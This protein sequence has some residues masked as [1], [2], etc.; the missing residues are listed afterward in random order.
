MLKCGITGHS[1][2]LGSQLIKKKFNFKFIIF[3]DDI[4]RKKKIYQWIKKN[5]LDLILH[6]AA[7]VPTKVVENNFSYANSVNYIGTKNLVDAIVE[8]NLNLKWFF[9]SSTS[10]VYSLPKKKIK[11]NEKCKKKAISKYGLTK[12]KAERYIK[13]KLSKSKIPYCIGRIF[14]FTHI[15]Q[16]DFYLIPSIVKKIRKS[17][18]NN[19]VFNNMNHYRDFVSVADI[20]EAIK[21]LWI[22]KSKGEFNIASGKATYIK[23][24]VKFLCKK[25]KKKPIFIDNGKS[26]M[27]GD[28]KK[29]NK[30]GWKSKKNIFQ[31][32]NEYLAVR[33]IF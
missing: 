25:Y 3:K 16:E 5:K 26:Y 22:K 11:I 32:L 8:N 23:N 17:K 18:K 4:C 1:G 10:H 9:F 15:N 33:R 24:I 19:I 28:V 21:L 14:S 7:I 12:L 6:I 20:C 31:I 27:V 13:K 29:I 2:T 30:L